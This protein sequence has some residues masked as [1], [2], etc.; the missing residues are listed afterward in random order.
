MNTLANPD[1][2]YDQYFRTSKTAPML[3]TPIHVGKNGK[4]IAETWRSNSSAVTNLPGPER[5]FV[6]PPPSRLSPG[7]RPFVTGSVIIDNLAF[8]WFGRIAIG[9]DLIMALII[10]ALFLQ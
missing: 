7:R 9:L 8:G 1:T 2:F 5:D 6:L 4:L 3:G 10:L